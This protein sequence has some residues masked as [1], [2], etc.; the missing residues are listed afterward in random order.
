MTADRPGGAPLG[1]LFRC[2]I[3]RVYGL[4]HI[5]TP[6]VIMMTLHS[7]R[8]RVNN[9]GHT[10]WVSLT[11]AG[12]ATAGNRQSVCPGEQHHISRYGFPKKFRI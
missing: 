4:R 11:V 8:S 5:L 7:E 2:G 12:R 1:M 3:L 9:H 6:E 10:S